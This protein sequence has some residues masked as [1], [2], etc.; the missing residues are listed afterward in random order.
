MFSFLGSL[1]ICVCVSA[2]S[3]AR[4]ELVVMVPG[5][6]WATCPQ[7]KQVCNNLYKEKYQ[8]RGLLL[9]KGIL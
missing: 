7:N 5:G 3:V 4:C 6:F 2:V 1:C 8:M 9:G